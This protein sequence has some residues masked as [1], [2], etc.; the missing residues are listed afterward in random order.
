MNSKE[1]WIAANKQTGLIRA[2]NRALL[3]DGDINNEMNQL[4][5]R[6]PCLIGV[7]GEE[8]VLV[9]KSSD[10]LGKLY[11]GGEA[12]PRDIGRAIELL[13]KSAE[14]NK[15]YAQYTLG[16]LYLDGE[17]VSQD[18]DRAIE[19]LTKS[20]E[21]G[22][23]FSQYWLGKIYI[24]GKLVPR[25]KEM[26]LHW[27]ELAAAQGNVYAQFFI[28]HINEIGIRNLD[29]FMSVTSL[30]GQ[31]ENIFNEQNSKLESKAIQLDSKRRK[32]LREKKLAQ[33][34]AIDE[35]IQDY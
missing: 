25:D 32:I 12:V 4:K 31:I 6:I 8:R 5:R 2:I 15:Q 17:A 23:Q 13:I 30:F 26:A 9:F 28:E 22:N 7:D 14:Q 20:A 11:L 34:H 18:I 24:M 16:K 1:I 21:Q 33:G 35:Q 27:F 3:R 10:T 19:L 29:I